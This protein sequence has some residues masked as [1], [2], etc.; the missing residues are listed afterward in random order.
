MLFYFIPSD[1][2]ET[3]PRE[4]RKSFK[5]QLKLL[6]SLNSW[7]RVVD[8]G[9]GILT[10]RS[11][12]RRFGY[13]VQIEINNKTGYGAIREFTPLAERLYQ[14]QSSKN[15]RY[16]GSFV[17]RQKERLQSNFGIND[18]R[19]QEL[20][21]KGSGV[22]YIWSPSM[23]YSMR[24]VNEVKRYAKSLGVGFFAFVDE[25]AEMASIKKVAQKFSI[26]ESDSRKIA[27]T[28]MDMR[29]YKLHFPTTY[30]YKNGKIHPERIIGVVEKLEFSL[31]V[32][33]RLNEL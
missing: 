5:N 30:V 15:C 22:L 19:L 1:A 16:Q 23:E 2:K 33:R 31:S 4:C 6:K 21:R 17:K 27:S 14:V 26:S 3:E 8:R 7:I 12:T 18:Q 11:P 28:E 24:R 9:L 25:R 32:H 10:F 29:Q 13:W 20:I